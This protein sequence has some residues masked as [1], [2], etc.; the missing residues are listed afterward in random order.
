[1]VK[2]SHTCRTETNILSVLLQRPVATAMHLHCLS[3][4]TL[5]GVSPQLQH[6]KRANFRTAH[7]V[8]DSLSCNAHLRR[9]LCRGTRSTHSPA[10]P[11]VNGYNLGGDVSGP[12]KIGVCQVQELVR[13][14]TAIVYEYRRWTGKH[15]VGVGGVDGEVAHIG[16]GGVGAYGGDEGVGTVGA[17]H[18]SSRTAS[19]T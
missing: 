5:N 9:Q 11:A 14:L 12:M 7:M 19:A 2:Q 18:T 17:A 1:M 16:V 3:T 4:S 6:T 10:D 13:R 15:I 8:L